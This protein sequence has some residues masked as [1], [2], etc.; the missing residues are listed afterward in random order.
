MIQF[1]KGLASGVVVIILWI[2]ENTLVATMLQPEAAACESPA[3]E[4]RV[5]IS[6]WPTPF[7][8]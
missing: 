3:W 7:P 6:D 5:G 8:A 2:Q 4:C 1:Y